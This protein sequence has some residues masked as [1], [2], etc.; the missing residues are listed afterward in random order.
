MAVKCLKRQKR[1]AVINDFS[2]F[3]RCSLTVSIPIIS[4]MRIQCCAVPTAILSNHT[5]YD[6]YFFDDYTDKM[7]AYYMKWEKLGLKFD[8]IYTG[9]L[10]SE[11]QAKIVEDFIERFS[12]RDTVV[13]VDPVMGDNGKTYATIDS[14]LCREIK[15]L[16]PVSDIITPNLTEACILTDTEYHE[17]DYDI[18]E[19]KEIA[20][21]LRCLGARN[22]VITGIR[23]ND[24]ICNFIL[25]DDKC[26]LLEYPVTGGSHAGTGD[27]FASII[28]ADAVNKVDFEESV[29]KS[30]EFVSR[31]VELSDKMQIPMQDGVCFEEILDL[32]M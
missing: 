6:D 24:D 30:A 13:T 12:D 21:R 3:G 17:D 20:L 22:I 15:N 9:F 31:C 18:G 2:G 32:L 25:T 7:Q 11:K 16:I 27:V 1:I 10:G 26:K 19:I 28:S 23:K 8:G 4:A 5:G 29:K 14:R